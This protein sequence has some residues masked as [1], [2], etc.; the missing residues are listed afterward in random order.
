MLFVHVIVLIVT[1]KA[2]RGQ[3][4]EWWR[5]EIAKKVVPPYTL[6]YSMLQKEI[7]NT[8][9]N[10]SNE[11]VS[12]KLLTTLNCGAMTLKGNLSLALNNSNS[13]EVMI[14]E[15]VMYLVQATADWEE[16]IKKSKSELEALHAK[17]KE[18]QKQVVSAKQAIQDKEESVA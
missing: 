10:I 5:H 4:L 15:T 16:K 12:T 3:D 2:V 17:V 13:I 7:L 6:G 8:L 14:E 1:L 18:A 11:S 9:L